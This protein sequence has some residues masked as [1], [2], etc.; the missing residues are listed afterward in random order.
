MK[1]NFKGIHHVTAMTDNIMRNYDFMTKILGVKLVKKTVNQDDIDTY[2]TF[3]A[4]DLGSS[5]TDM[6]FFD[7][8]GNYKGSHGTNEISRAGLRVP[9]DEALEYWKERFDKFNVKYGEVREEFGRKVLDFEESDGQRYK[10][11]SDENDKGVAPGI[12]YKHSD[13]PE[14]YAIVGLGPVEIRVS[15]YDKFKEILE[16]LFEFRF[17]EEINEN[18]SRISLYEVGEG[19]NGARIII[20]E[21]VTSNEAI[22]GDGSIHHVAFRVENTEELEYW[23]NKMDNLGIRNSGYVNRYYFES[24]YIRI[25]HILFEVATDGP[26]FMQ[27]EDYEYMGEKLSLPP[28]L[29]EKREEIEKQVRP[30]NTIREKR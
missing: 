20:I 17:V 15:Y 29:E 2:H 7:F 10:L 23:I 6:T 16:E 26:G 27:D 3:Y 24:L 28:F 14:K 8:Q 30:F 1:K 18:N 11:V 5:G 22:Q 9:S 19:G 21:D 4:D 25:G 13:V 12:A